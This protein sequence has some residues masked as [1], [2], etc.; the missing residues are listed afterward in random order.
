MLKKVY[1][2]EVKYIKENL[3]FCL[4][5]SLIKTHFDCFNQKGTKSLK[6]ISNQKLYRD[7]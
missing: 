5:E 7:L 4:E 6:F 1:L 2:F 3:S